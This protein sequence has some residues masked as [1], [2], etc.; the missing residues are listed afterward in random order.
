MSQPWN[1]PPPPPGAPV[2][3]H[4]PIAIIATI[5]SVI[6]CCIPHGVVSLIFSL[7]VNK[8]VEAGDMVGAI[9]AAR[10]AKMW[11]FISIGV[12]VVGLVLS[13]ILGVLNAVLSTMGNV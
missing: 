5:V 6:F 11:G 2:N 9:N 7:Q 13:I 8:K 1:P 10:Q 12:A 3:N 4:L